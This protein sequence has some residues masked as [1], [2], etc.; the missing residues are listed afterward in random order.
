M[1]LG[2]Q[3]LLSVPHSHLYTHPVQYVV[4]SDSAGFGTYSLFIAIVV[5]HSARAC[6]YVSVLLYVELVM[7]LWVFPGIFSPHK[8]GC[9]AGCFPGV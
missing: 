9:S 2:L 5:G 1:L 8:R 4:E 3:S 6:E 7:F